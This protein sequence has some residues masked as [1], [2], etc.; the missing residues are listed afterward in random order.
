MPSFL[1]IRY[2]KNPKPQISQNFGHSFSLAFPLGLGS[3]GAVL[4]SLVSIT[5]NVPPCCSHAMYQRFAGVKQ[6]LSLYVC[7]HIF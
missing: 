7:E 2:L 4:S 5:F 1:P 6:Y 3:Y